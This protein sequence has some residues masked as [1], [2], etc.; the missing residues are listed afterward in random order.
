MFGTVSYLGRCGMSIYAKDWTE[1][2]AL[3]SSTWRGIRICPLI[4]LVSAECP[5]S[6]V[7][8]VCELS[9]WFEQVYDSNPQ[10]MRDA[11]H[12]TVTAMEM[13]STGI[14]QLEVME[15]YKVVLLSSLNTRSL[16]MPVTFCS[17]NSRPVT[18]TE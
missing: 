14:T 18:F 15:S 4:P 2:V 13:H 7:R 1:V 12:N 10:G 11:W 5:G 6:V 16:D 9:T 17:N 8:E 3:S